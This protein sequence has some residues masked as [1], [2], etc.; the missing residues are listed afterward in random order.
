M[1]LISFVQ[2]SLVFFTLVRS[3]SSEATDSPCGSLDSPVSDIHIAKIAKD[4]I[5]NWEELGPYLRLLPV[6]EYEI[7]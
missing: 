7:N 5:R 6:H 4:F 3:I 2:R 1:K